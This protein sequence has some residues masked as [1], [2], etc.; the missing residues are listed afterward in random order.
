MI[1][2]N[3]IS[4]TIKFVTNNFTNEIFFGI[5]KMLCKL[6]GNLRQ[7]LFKNIN[8]TIQSTT[9]ASDTMLPITYGSR[10]REWCR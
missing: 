8:E 1:Q 2:L 9:E 7:D 5:I 6:N 10:I 3:I 4:F